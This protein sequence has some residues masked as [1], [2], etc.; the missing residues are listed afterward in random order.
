[1]ALKQGY[2]AGLFKSEKV[3]LDGESTARARLLAGTNGVSGKFSNILSLD[4]WDLTE[5]SG[6]IS[7]GA[8]YGLNGLSGGCKIVD[9]AVDTKLSQ[10]ITLASAI[11]EAKKV[12]ISLW[13]KLQTTKE[14][15]MTV[16][17]KTSGGVTIGTPDVLTITADNEY[18]G[19]TEWGYWSMFLTLPVTALSFVIDIEPTAA[20]TLYLDDVNV[21]CVR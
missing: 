20:Q 10:T 18:Y 19:D 16:T 15:T 17:F 11:T 13:A 8:A 1:M 4:W 3:L 21:V 7:W 2:L 5:G 6:S 12:S 9:T 14:A